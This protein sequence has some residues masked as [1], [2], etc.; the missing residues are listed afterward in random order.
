[1]STYD[2]LVK[3]IK[4]RESIRVKKELGLPKPWT[5]DPIL[6]HYRFCNV[7]RNDD[8]VSQWIFEN[9]IAP[10][11]GSAYLVHNIIASRMINWPDTLEEVGFLHPWDEDKFVDRVR[12][13]IARGD[14][15]WTGAY[16]ITA[17]HDGTPKEVSVARTIAMVDCITP[18]NNSC[19]RAWR[20]LKKLPRIGS[21]MAAQ[22]VADFKRTYILGTAHDYET[23]CAPGPGSM[24]GLNV[25][26]GCDINRKWEQ[27]DFEDEVNYIR[28][29]IPIRL[30]AQNVQNC[31]C[32]FYKYHRGKSR[33]TYPGV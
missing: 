19:H 10:N 13:R 8:K 30:D 5:D 29:V 32:E 6:Q 4:E 24:K 22:F 25:L 9:W 16:M 28:S 26:L 15:T 21:F 17:E 14:K 27:Y 2:P 33:S 23:F 11:E 20:Q 1:M 3:F 18:L 7:N 31:L 12:S